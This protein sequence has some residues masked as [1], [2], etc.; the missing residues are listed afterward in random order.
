MGKVLKNLLRSALIHLVWISIFALIFVLVLKDLQLS[1]VFFPLNE[2]GMQRRFLWRIGKP[3]DLRSY[4]EEELIK[5]SQNLRGSAGDHVLW[6]QIRG[7]AKYV[8]EFL[9]AWPNQ[10]LLERK[11]YL[12][13]VA[14]ALLQKNDLVNGYKLIQEYLALDPSDYE[15]HLIKGLSLLSSDVEKAIYH[16]QLAISYSGGDVSSYA[17]VKIFDTWRLSSDS[18]LLAKNPSVE[19]LFWQLM[20]GLDN[21]VWGKVKLMVESAPN[22]NSDRNLLISRARYLLR[23]GDYDEGV[24]DLIRANS[25]EGFYKPA[26]VEVSQVYKKQKRFEKL[27]EVYNQIAE[28]DPSDNWVWNEIED[29]YIN[30]MG[31]Y[32]KAYEFF[33]KLIPK[34][35]QPEIK[36]RVGRILFQLGDHTMAKRF[37]MNYLES[38]PESVEALDFLGQISLKEQQYQETTRVISLM[39]AIDVLDSRLWMLKGALSFARGQYDEAVAF[40]ERV[41]VLDGAFW[42]RET[43][44]LCESYRIVKKIS[45]AVACYGA[46]KPSDHDFDRAQ[47]LIAESDLVGSAVG[48]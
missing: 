17:K 1:K 7:D 35:N 19:L 41:Q 32:E 20:S 8:E 29:F 21:G 10:K 48:Q 45:K 43:M 15:V 2:I 13:W 26:A 27:I 25:V 24:K 38:A 9:T 44:K 6:A 36:L 18:G 23:A 46:V 47:R 4:F 3:W 37:L 42:N 22:G 40:F 11:K 16:L 30:R 34:S 28:K 14:F 33:S 39:E 12:K 31:N 5:K